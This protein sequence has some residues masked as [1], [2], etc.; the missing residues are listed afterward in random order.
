MAEHRVRT[1]ASGSLLTLAIYGLL[2]AVVDRATGALVDL[3]TTAAPG[4]DPGLVTTGLAVALWVGLALV[5]ANEAHRQYTAT[6]PALDGPDRVR[7]Y[8]AERR[9]GRRESVVWVA[10]LALGGAV[11]VVGFES[12]VAVLDRVPLAGRRLAESGA[13]EVGVVDLVRAAG[14]LV[15]YVLAAWG[16]D[17]LVVGLARELQYRRVTA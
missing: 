6:S 11:A 7:S 16:L 17:R 9:P 15:G 3:L 14:F 4:T 2:V 5:V 8:L 10:A 12:F 1:P 13:A